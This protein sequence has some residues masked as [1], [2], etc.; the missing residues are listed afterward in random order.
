M[1]FRGAALGKRGKG[2]RGW[3][4]HVHVHHGD[5]RRESHVI[6][7]FDHVILAVVGISIRSFDQVAVHITLRLQLS[8]ETRK[9]RKTRESGHGHG[10]RHGHRHGW[11]MRGESV[12]SVVLRSPSNYLVTALAVMLVTVMVTNMRRMGRMVGA[13]TTTSTESKAS[14]KLSE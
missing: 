3:W 2:G 4:G 10:H 12:I 8:R 13:S 5:C 7:I 6:I 11:M 1:S 9:T 14:C